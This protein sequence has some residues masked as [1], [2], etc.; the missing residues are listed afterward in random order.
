MIVYPGI[1]VSPLSDPR[2]CEGSG[3]VSFGYSKAA[4]KVAKSL[5]SC[6]RRNDEGGGLAVM[7]NLDLFHRN[8]VIRQHVVRP[9][10]NADI[11]AGR[12]WNYL[13]MQWQRVDLLVECE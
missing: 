1:F 11:A 2:P 4:A 9:M 8:P 10:H 3:P 13:P 6:L 7:K 5:G 12:P